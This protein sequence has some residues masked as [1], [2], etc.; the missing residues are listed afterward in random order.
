V[1]SVGAFKIASTSA[2]GLDVGGSP[3][4]V[5]G[6]ASLARSSSSLNLDAPLL[7]SSSLSSGADDQRGEVSLIWLVNVLRGALIKAFD[8]GA[9]A[10]KSAN[11][12]TDTRI[13]F[14]LFFKH[15]KQFFKKDFFLFLSF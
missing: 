6:V 9:L 15:T 7:P 10:R 5:D 2:S 3:V 1:Y 12:W 4:D 11:D 13:F 8:S 14:F